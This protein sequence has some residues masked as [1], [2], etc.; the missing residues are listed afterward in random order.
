MAISDSFSAGADTLFLVM[1][2]LAMLGA[3]QVLIWMLFIFRTCSKPRYEGSKKEMDY[4][5]ANVDGGGKDAK[6]KLTKRAVK[7]HS[8]ASGNNDLEDSRGRPWKRYGCLHQWQ[9]RSVM[10]M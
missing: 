8:E 6:M 1:T 9:Q 2:C 3:I 4:Q 10:E 5:Q 7:K